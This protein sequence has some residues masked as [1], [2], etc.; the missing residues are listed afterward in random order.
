MPQLLQPAGHLSKRE[1]RGK[2]LRYPRTLIWVGAHGWRQMA[3]ESLVV[4]IARTVLGL[5]L[6]ALLGLL[7]YVITVPVVLS[8][9][10]PTFVNYPLMGM[11]AVGVGAGVGSFLAWL[12]RESPLLV[13]VVLL[14]LSLGLA[15][16][17]A[18]GGY[19]HG[20]DVYRLGGTLG[21]PALSATIVGGI[22]GANLPHVALGVLKAIRRPRV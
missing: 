7:L 15:M 10:E 2:V 3:L 17:G 1:S 8:I 20:K 4:V 5:F 21:I 6:S 22:L 16:A 13:L 11:V 14:A 12:D 18:W 19:E 9:W